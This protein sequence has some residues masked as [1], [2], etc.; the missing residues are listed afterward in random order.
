M[1]LTHYLCCVGS[2]ILRSIS[3]GYKYWQ[4]IVARSFLQ[5]ISNRGKAGVPICMLDVGEGE[6]SA[7]SQICSFIVLE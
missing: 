7:F 5:H 4:N 6:L 3:E 2:G 1:S